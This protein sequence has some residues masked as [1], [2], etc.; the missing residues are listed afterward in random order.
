MKGGMFAP[1]MAVRH[2]PIPIYSKTPENVEVG[3]EYHC[4]MSMTV[5]FFSFIF[6]IP[7]GSRKKKTEKKNSIA[8]R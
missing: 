5:H 3:K 2:C 4:L 6:S 1:P 7:T 8:G